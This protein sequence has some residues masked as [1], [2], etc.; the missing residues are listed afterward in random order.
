MPD[1]KAR[2]SFIPGLALA[3]GFYREIVGPILAAR[4][5]A[6]RYS[7]ALIGHGSEVLQFDTEM[8]TDHN[9]GPRVILFLTPEEYELKRDAIRTF[10]SRELPLTYRGY[11]TNF[12]E[13]N[14][15][16][17]GSQTL[18]SISSGPVNHRV[19]TYTLGGFFTD[20]LNIDINVN[21]EPIDWL[22]LP[23]QKLRAVTAG[24]VFRD[25]LGLEEIRK[26]FLWYPHDVWLY[27]LASLWARIGQDEHLMGRA[28]LAG[29]ENGSALIAARLVRDIMRLA[30]LMEREYPPYPKWLGTAFSRLKSATKLGPVLSDALHAASWQERESHLCAAYEI[31]AEMHNN[32]KITG[33]I[34][35]EV[36]LFW[37][38]PFRVIRGERFTAAIVKQIQEPQIT[39]LSKCSPIGSIDI[40]TD[41]ND[42]LEDASLRP[43]L[44]KLYE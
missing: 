29:D 27:I 23:Q 18:H 13:P 10:L 24:K 8:S 1:K 38:R 26:R 15:E 35:P 11:P 17:N 14:P 21:L 5:P 12:S 34:S 16:D 3:E 19:E 32:L 9:W 39:P 30:M 28:G 31:L 20:Y 37:E 40:F 44:R 6:L 7:A 33:P 22:T 25:G 2:P 43:V 36:S 42:M 41:N 4:F